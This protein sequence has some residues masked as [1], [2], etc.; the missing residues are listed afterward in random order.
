M[1]LN[2]RVGTG[3]IQYYLWLPLRKVG[4]E[5]FSDTRVSDVLALD[6]VGLTGEGNSGPANFTNDSKYALVK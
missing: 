4:D 1:M 2:L 3:I 6:S 5:L